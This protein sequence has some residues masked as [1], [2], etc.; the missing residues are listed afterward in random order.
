[1]TK[2]CGQRCPIA[3]LTPVD[4]CLPGLTD[5]YHNTNCAKRTQTVTVARVSNPCGR[6][7]A[8]SP[9]LRPV[10]QPASNRLTPVDLDL[11]ALTGVYRFADLAKRT[12]AIATS[13]RDELREVFHRG[14]AETNGVFGRDRSV[15]PSKARRD[16]RP[17]SNHSKELVDG[18]VRVACLA[19]VQRDVALEELLETLFGRLCCGKVSPH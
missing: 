9:G 3:R 6:R 8:L 15:G 7:G 10:P 12:N 16:V 18:G 13:L 1:M 19:D 5:V 14:R 17:A 4:L 2:R 11:P